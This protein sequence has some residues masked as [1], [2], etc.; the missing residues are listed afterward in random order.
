MTR[1]LSLILLGALLFGTYDLLAQN[2]QQSKALASKAG[3]YMVGF[4]SGVSTGV[5]SGLTAGAASA[6]SSVA[7][8]AGSLVGSFSK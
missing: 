8:T 6:A 3:S 2:G 5:F 7:T 1:I 4:K